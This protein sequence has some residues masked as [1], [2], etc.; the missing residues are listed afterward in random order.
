MVNMGGNA[1]FQVLTLAERG[2]AGVIGNMRTLGG[3]GGD[4]GD[5][6]YMGEAAA[7]AYGLMMAQKDALILMTRTM[8][9]G[10]SADYVTKIDLRTRRALGSTDNLLDV[11]ES[12]SNGEYVKSA[13]D[14]LGIAT[15]LPGRFLATED[16]YF[17][18]ITM[19]RVLYRE[20][21]RATQIA[22]TS[23][24]KTGKSREQAK[25][26]SEAAY[27]KVMTNT[28]KE[29]SDMMTIEARKMTFQGQP[30]GFMGRMGGSNPKR[31]WN[32]NGHT[33]L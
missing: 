28:P 22:Y 2:L 16:E 27:L 18:V 31:T 9:T 14:T 5:Q 26:I 1:S 13:I 21:H 19:R 33:I 6:R 4:V 12:I 17:K 24:R 23:A 10:D 20:A 32:E 11:A 29:I 3:L 25:A 8:I 30:A 7:E 15:R